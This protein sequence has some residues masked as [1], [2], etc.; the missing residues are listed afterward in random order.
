MSGTLTLA[1]AGRGVTRSVLCE[2]QFW[3]ESGWTIEH[4]EIGA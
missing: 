2:V 1:A 4:V 3:P